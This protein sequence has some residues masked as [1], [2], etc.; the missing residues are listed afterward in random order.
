MPV[1]PGGQVVC[2][3]CGGRGHNSRSCG[4]VPFSR[5]RSRPTKADSL[6]LFYRLPYPDYLAMVAEG[7]GICR[8]DLNDRTPDVDH[9][10]ACDHPGKGTSSCR[11]CVRGVLCRS[12][13][14]R[15]GAFE[16]GLRDDAAIAAYLAAHLRSLP[17]ERERYVLFE[18]A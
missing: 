11:A 2:G 18:V 16:R 1:K 4:R 12:C 5:G 7:C 14:L 3:A 17:T 8:C 13:N 10:H 6:R 9:D 15:V